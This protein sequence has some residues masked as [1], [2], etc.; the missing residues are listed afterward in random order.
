[1]PT[2]GNLF[3]YETVYISDGD[4]QNWVFGKCVLLRDFHGYKKGDKIDAFVTQLLLHGFNE[5]D[6]MIM[7]DSVRV[8]IQD[9]PTFPYAK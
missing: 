9:F 7:D 6:E 5:K 4:E 2:L 1:M 8:C 3:T